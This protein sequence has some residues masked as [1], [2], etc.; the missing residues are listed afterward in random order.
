MKN[1]MDFI[2]LESRVLECYTYFMD[3]HKTSNFET[4]EDKIKDLQKVMTRLTVTNLV[5]MIDRVVEDG[6]K[7]R[8]SENRQFNVSSI[9]ISDDSKINLICHEVVAYDNIDKKY[10]L[11]NVQSYINF[12]DVVR[13]Y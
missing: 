6:R 4:L 1:S 3:N 10:I 7:N 12:A 11:D 8:N 2:G 9:Q 5:N 13:V